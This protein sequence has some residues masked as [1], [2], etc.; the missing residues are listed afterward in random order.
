MSCSLRRQLLTEVWGPGHDA[1]TNYLR[2]YMASLRRKLEPIPARP[3]HLITEPGMGGNVFS[4]AQESLSGSATAASKSSARRSSEPH[5][6]QLGR[7]Q[8]TGQLLGTQHTG[9]SPKQVQGAHKG[10]PGTVHAAKLMRQHRRPIR[11]PPN[12]IGIGQIDHHHRRAVGHRSKHGPSARVNCGSSYT[13]ADTPPAPQRANVGPVEDQR[14]R[15]RV[16]AE[17]HHA[18][19]TQPIGGPDAPPVADGGKQLFL[20]RHP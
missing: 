18:G 1:D 8:R 9:V 16:D 7:H 14:N 10:H 17:Q 6:G 13:R 11:R 20:N 12:N 15:R 3:R 5:L 19:L 2:T 4:S